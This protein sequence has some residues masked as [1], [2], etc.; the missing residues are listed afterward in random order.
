M[1]TKFIALFSLLVCFGLSG[2]QNDQDV[3]WLSDNEGALTITKIVDPTMYETEI[4]SAYIDKWVK[5]Y[6]TNLGSVTSITLNDVEVRIPQDA[7]IAGEVIQFRVPYAIPGRV[8]NRLT[9]SNDKESFTTQLKV[10]IPPMQIDGMD[11][12]Y[13]QVGSTMTINGDYFDLYGVTIE[14]GKVMFDD[15]EAAIVSASQ[16]AISVI[17]PEGA[18]LN[19]IVSIVGDSKVQC[20]GRYCDSRMLLE[21]FEAI[22]IGQQPDGCSVDEPKVV[23]AGDPFPSPGGA[24]YLYTKYHATGAYDRIF[25]VTNYT[26]PEAFATDRGRYLIKFEICT[27]LPLLIPFDFELNDYKYIWDQT[28]FD[29]HGKWVTVTIPL[30]EWGTGAGNS[31]AFYLML[32]YNGSVAA[33]VD[34]AVDNFR[35]SPADE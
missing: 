17:V 12:E 33:D 6:G 34:M 4:S 20:P 35:L 14:N 2:C 30:S 31:H 19:S 13:A 9:I 3:V 28:P 10:D 8:D 15:V 11:C 27:K 5:L 26:E 22:T 32:N 25:R 18:P 7:V 23:G 21:N 24:K 29:T 16:K 1:K